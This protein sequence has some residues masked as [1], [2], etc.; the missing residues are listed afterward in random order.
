MK[1]KKSIYEL[2]RELIAMIALLGVIAVVLIVERQG[3]HAPA[4]VNDSGLLDEDAWYALCNDEAGTID[5]TAPR[6]LVIYDDNDAGSVALKDN[7]QYVLT[8]LYVGSETMIVTQGDLEAIHSEGNPY[9][10]GGRDETTVAEEKLIRS[11]IVLPLSDY[12]ELIICISDLTYFNVDM[13][14]LMAWV[15][16]GGH[17]LFAEALE[18]NEYLEVWY[19]LLGIATEGETPMTFAESL[20]FNTDLMAGAKGM[21]FSDDVITCQVLAPNLESLCEVHATTSGED[22]I[23][24]LWELPYGSGRIFVCNADIMESKVDR[25]IVSSAYCRFYPA[26]A[27]P[28]INASI[29]CVDDCPSPSPAGFEK[30]VLAQYGYTVADFYANVWMPAMQDIAEKYGVRFSTF[31]IQTYEDDVDGPF[32]NI[33]NWESS[34]YYANLILNMG[35]EIGIHGYNHQPLIQEGYELDE[36][37][38]GYT[39]WNNVRD[40]IA[41]LKECIRYTE[42]LG[43]DLYAKSYVAPSNVISSEALQEMLAQLED[44]R[45]YA[46]VYSGTSDQ[47]IQEFSVLDNGVVFCP[48]LTADMQMEDSEWWTQI[49]ELNFHYVESNFIHPDDIL[50]EDRSDGGDFSQ[51]LSGYEEMIQ[52]NT[53]Q[54]LRI[55]TISEAGAAVQRY[56][57]LSVVQDFEENELMIHITGVIDEAYMMLRTNGKRP[58][59][60][61]G[62]TM[63]QLSDDIYLLKIDST[64]VKI[65]MVDRT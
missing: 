1:P 26:Y 19:P 51:M 58:V 21:E 65:T 59:S 6:A 27:Y 49:N 17:V 54:G 33:D 30:N 25:G 60:I 5:V 44:I 3:F 34:S 53:A 47:F 62:G 31:T 22:E 13:G 11:E 16:D 46:G 45:V 15:E 55:T 23:P 38:S 43:D 37:N 24:L 39:P 42:S 2:Y 32:D 41:A 29:Y 8:S 14:V 40:M 7:I 64:T 61:K 4:A 18:S 28:V 36:E 20:I 56:A 9:R 48:R 57:N 12:Q 52:W 50:D 10:Q 63:K 35:G